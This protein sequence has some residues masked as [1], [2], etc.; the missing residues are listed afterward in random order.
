MSVVRKVI[1]INPTTYRT[2]KGPG[3]EAP[4]MEIYSGTENRRIIRRVMSSKFSPTA[5][6]DEKLAQPI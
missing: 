4:E 1:K 2:Q 6:E 3:S 5:T